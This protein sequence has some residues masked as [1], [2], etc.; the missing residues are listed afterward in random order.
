MLEKVTWRRRMRIPRRLL[1]RYRESA[2]TDR[3]MYHIVHLRSKGMFS[4]TSRFSWGHKL[5]ADKARK[6]FL[7]DQAEVRRS[8][9]NEARKYREALEEETKKQSF[10]HVCT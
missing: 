8:K 5:K 4:K 7:A 6:K 3:H 9:T 2:K 10:L 1:R